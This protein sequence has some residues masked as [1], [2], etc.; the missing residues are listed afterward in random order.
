MLTI[1]TAAIEVPKRLTEAQVRFFVE[2]GYLIVPKLLS[3]EEVEE[4]RQ[5]TIKVA[6]GG[7]PAKHCRRSP[8]T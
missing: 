1:P 5:D 7:Y 3:E 4:L 6:R 8:P 2:N